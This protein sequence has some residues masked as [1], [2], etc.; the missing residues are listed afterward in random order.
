MI[1]VCSLDKGVFYMVDKFNEKTIHRETIFKGHVIDVY[2]DDVSLPNQEISKRELVFHQ[3]AVGILAITS[4]D[5]IVLVRQFRKALEK[6]ILEIPAGKIEKDELDLAKTAKREL[7]EETHY[8]CKK[9]EKVTSFITSPGF[10]NEEL[11]LYQAFDL[12][13]V[14]NPLPR[15]E[16]EFLDII[17]LTLTQAKEEIKKGTICDAKTMYALLYWESQQL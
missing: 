8:R 6:S 14:D 1:I 13:K 15:D 9:L 7:E 16:D 10:C 2:V 12:E 4:E 11:T 5:K 3:G 17:E